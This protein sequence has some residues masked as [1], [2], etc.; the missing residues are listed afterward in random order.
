MLIKVQVQTYK[1]IVSINKKQ[2]WKEYFWNRI[3]CLITT[4]GSPIDIVRRYTE[5]QGMK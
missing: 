4:G 2:L 1:K 3:Y 5:N